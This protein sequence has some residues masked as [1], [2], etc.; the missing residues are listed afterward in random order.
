M[1]DKFSQIKERF[2]A[3]G[4]MTYTLSELW[5]QS[6]GPFRARLLNWEEGECFMVLGQSPVGVKQFYGFFE[7]GFVCGYEGNEP[8]WVKV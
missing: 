6:G 4:P 5:Q 8:G 7:N 1:Q 2:Q 3:K